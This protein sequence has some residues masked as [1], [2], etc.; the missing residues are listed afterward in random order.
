MSCTARSMTTPTF[1]MRGGNGPTRVI[2]IDRMSSP[3]IASLI[4]WTVGLKRST[5]PTI[6][7]TPARRA[8]S[9]MALALLHRGRDR[10]LHHHVNAA[11]DAGERD[12]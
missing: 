5:W 12:L 8:A 3:R 11:G 10:L 9:M 2:A 7:A 4:A 6:S 1:D